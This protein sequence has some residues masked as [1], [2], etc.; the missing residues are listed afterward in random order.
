MGI[1][2]AW[3]L[4]GFIAALGASGALVAAATGA[5]GAYFTDSHDGSISAS[6]GHL[7][8]GISGDMSMN[9]ANLMPGTPESK[10]ITYTTHVSSTGTE[11]IWLVL[12]PGAA[13]DGL[14]G[15]KDSTLFPG[16][17]LGRYGYFAV[18]DS[19]GG[20]AFRSHNLAAPPTPADGGVCDVNAN[21]GRGGS[22]QVETQT[23]MFPPYCAIPHDILLASN[24]SN[25]AT[26]TITITFGLS[27]KQ[28]DQGQT[29]FGGSVPFS[30]VATQHNV[31]PDAPNL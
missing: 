10:S 1:S 15:P 26:G 20:T 23:D 28:T 2:K 30:I 24:L 5:T 14:T 6:S 21:T 4:G 9:F 12:P 3:R 17:G 8:L 7:S 18:S 31:R 16:G 22:D 27:G 11:D 25:G 19:N 13:Y 29:E